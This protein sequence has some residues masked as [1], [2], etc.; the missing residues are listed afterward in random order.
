MGAVICDVVVKRD[1]DMACGA[2]KNK[3]DAFCYSHWMALPKALR[4][5]VWR[6]FRAGQGS[7]AH[8]LALTECYAFLSAPIPAGT[9]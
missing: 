2:K 3:L 1:P 5:E 8:I 4:D 9:D 7:E 6:T